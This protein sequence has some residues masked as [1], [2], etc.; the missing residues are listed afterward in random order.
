MPAKVKHVNPYAANPSRRI[1]DYLQPAQLMLPAGNGV[2]MDKLL[3]PTTAVTTEAT[4][5]ALTRP[6][7]PAINS[8]I[9][10][11]QA[12]AVLAERLVEDWRRL[13]IPSSP[14][15][16]ALLAAAIAENL[17][18]TD[19]FALAK[20]LGEEGFDGLT[21][22]D[23]EILDGADSTITEIHKQHVRDWVR[24]CDIQ[25]QYAV[26]TLVEFQEYN[27][28]TRTREKRTGLIDRIIREDGIYLV[29]IEGKA[30]TWRMLKYEEV[31]AI[32][33]TQ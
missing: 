9:I 23:V 3:E 31:T 24:A 20:A 6:P 28:L 10:R 32:A 17:H 7:R 1:T 27:S 5:E 29:P 4:T 11:A 12:A 16:Q 8:D 33:E 26:G 25:P 13:D 22:R 14:T 30:Q 21:A 19:G 15:Q 2:P 18:D